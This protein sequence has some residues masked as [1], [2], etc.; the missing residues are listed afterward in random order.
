MSNCDSEWFIEP[1]QQFAENVLDH[2]RDPF[3]DT[4]LF[5]DAIDPT[6]D[7]PLPFDTV[8]FG[9]ETVDCNLVSQQE[10]LRILVG[11][12][13]LTDDRTYRDA[14]EDTMRYALNNVTDSTGLPYWGV[15]CT[16]DLENKEPNHRR[17]ERPAHCLKSNYPFYELMWAADPAATERFVE[18][19]WNAHVEDWSNLDFNRWAHY[20]QSTDGPWIN[21][22]EGGEPFF[23]GDGLTFANAGSDMFYA[24]GKLAALGGDDAPLEWADR[25]AGRY[26]ETRHPDVGISGY[27]FSQSKHAG[28]AAPVLGDPRRERC[29]S[30]GDRAQH[31]FA[32]YLPEDRVVYEGTIFRPR[33]AV[34]R[35]QLLLGESLGGRGEQFTRWA[36]EEL[37][38]WRKAAYRPDENTFEPML[39]DGYSLEGFVHQRNGYFG[40]E[41]DTVQPIEATPQFFW[42]YATAYRVADEDVLWETA[43]HIGRGIGLGDIG[44]DDAA[45]TSAN[46]GADYRILFGLLELYRATGEETYLRA[47]VQRGEELIDTRFEDGYFMFDPDVSVVGSH[48]PLALLHLAAA[49]DGVEETIP[50]SGGATL[51]YEKQPGRD[52]SKNF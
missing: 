15:S 22:Y 8:S 11:L 23:W 35:A 6:T 34:Q 19:Y 42:V 31:Q 28:C 48:V 51:G 12:T 9:S 46:D 39:T 45:I 27:Q 16:F 29:K 37:K 41:G 25:L 43:R 4:P 38:A 52:V 24:A 7:E 1:V 30:R 17:P 3:D 26:V 10:F 50:A 33:P 20:D 36:I 18:A 47:A 21:E 13:R 44:G 49:I 2:G 5:V 32:P 40:T 14:A